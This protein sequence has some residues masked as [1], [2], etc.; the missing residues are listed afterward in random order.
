MNF[1][2]YLYWVILVVLLIWG[3]INDSWP[4]WLVIRIGYIILVPL[5]VWYLIGWA[6]NYWKPNEKLETNLKRIL[7][8]LICCVL[9]IF[10][11]LEANSKIH[12]GNTK[13]IRTRDGTEAIGDDIVLQGPD[14][15]IVLVLVIIAMLFLWFGVVKNR[16]SQSD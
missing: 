9:L 12:I 14:W 3:P 8:G 5:I 1:R 2:N 15:V 10:A 4:A 11:V 7:S 6:W 13:W 16:A